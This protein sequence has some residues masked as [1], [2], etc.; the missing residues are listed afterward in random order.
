MTDIDDDAL[1]ILAANDDVPRDEMLLAEV[2]ARYDGELR[3]YGCSPG[4]CGWCAL[5]SIPMPDNVTEDDLAAAEA[6]DAYWQEG[7]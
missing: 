6:F 2:I 1:D 4:P 3:I 7:A 5:R